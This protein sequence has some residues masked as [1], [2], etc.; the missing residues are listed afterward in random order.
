MN[1]TDRHNS[2]LIRRVL[3]FWLIAVLAA[4]LGVTMLHLHGIR[5]I[6][7][8]QYPEANPLQLAETYRVEGQKVYREAAEA[9]ARMKDDP[10]RPIKMKNLPALQKARTLFL[11]SL[12][13]KPNMSG[14]YIYLG[15]LSAFEGDTASMY[16]YRGMQAMSE[17]YAPAA[18]DEF[19]SALTH[20]SDFHPAQLEKARALIT[21]GRTSDARQLIDDLIKATPNDPDVLYLK[22][23]L[24]AREGKTQ[25]YRTA[26]ED[27]LKAEPWHLLSAKALGTLLTDE[28]Q[29]DRAISIFKEVRKAYPNDANLLHRLGRAY[30]LKGDLAQARKTLETALKLEKNSAPLY[31]DLACVYEKMG[32]KSYATAMLQK[33]IEIDPAFKNRILFPDVKH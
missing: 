31:F 11:E 25:E 19:D 17:N 14:I 5:L 1:N 18:L 20:K 22:A 3:P 23:E 30:Y 6:N 4:A 21:L 24:A 15:D 7:Y 10:E 16:Y 32:K 2:T 8:I 29:Y 26:L 27:V 12:K 9:F 13:L 28:R 33:A